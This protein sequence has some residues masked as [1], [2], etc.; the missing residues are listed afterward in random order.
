MSQARSSLRRICCCGSVR[1][2]TSGAVPGLTTALSR[3]SL[4]QTKSHHS[5]KGGDLKN[6]VSASQI[7]MDAYD[8][9]PLD[10]DPRSFTVSGR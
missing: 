7:M 9:D 8:A 5:M 6:V 1:S 4:R 3:H 2:G 10:K